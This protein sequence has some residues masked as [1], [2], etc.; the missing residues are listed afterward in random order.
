LG[1]EGGGEEER[2]ESEVAHGGRGTWDLGG[3]VRVGLEKGAGIGRGGL[4]GL[5]AE[6]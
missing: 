3:F 5:H 4:R 6:R 2:E 1:L